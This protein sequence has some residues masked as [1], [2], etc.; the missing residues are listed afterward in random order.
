[1][2]LIGFAIT[3][4]FF[5]G[6]LSGQFGVGG[7][8]ITTPGLRLILNTTAGIALGTPLPVIIP[9]AVA[10]SIRYS[11]EG[12]VE[13][14][15]VRYLAPSGLLGVLVGAYLTGYVSPDIPLLVTS[16]LI[17]ILAIGYLFPGKTR[18]VRVA[19]PAGSLAII[20]GLVAGFFSG[21]LGIGGGVLL[22]PALN[23]LLGRP[24]KN[25]LGTSLVTVA[26]YALPGTIIHYALGHIDVGIM[27]L[28]IVGVIPGALLGSWSAVRMNEVWLRRLF[29]IFLLFAAVYFGVFEALVL[30]RSMA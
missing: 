21:F 15:L 29:G 24:L 26:F 19:I 6:F 13:W 4:G 8:L 27:L 9:S 30:A 20:I 5:A 25:S 16:V 17:F 18:S 1:M 28:L 3:I 14:G 12:F 11:R 2:A 10:G 23:H 22:I 7:G